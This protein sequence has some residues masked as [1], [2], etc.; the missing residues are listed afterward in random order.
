MDIASIL[1]DAH[2]LPDLAEKVLHLYLASPSKS[3]AAPAFKVHVQLGQLLAQRGDQEV[4]KRE[5]VAA[6]AL[7]MSYAPARKALQGS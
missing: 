4:A 3:E 1:T 2:R 5:Y 7:A 6:L